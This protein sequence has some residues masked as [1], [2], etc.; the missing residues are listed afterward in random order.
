MKFFIIV[1]FNAIFFYLGLRVGK[2]LANKKA[3]DLREVK[4]NAVEELTEELLTK[5]I[6]LPAEVRVEI[7]KDMIGE[8]EKQKNETNK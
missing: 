8:Y 5:F 2:G 6:S 4:D 3:Q 7:L 1:L